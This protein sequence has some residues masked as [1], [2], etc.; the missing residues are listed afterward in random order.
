[1]AFRDYLIIKL[2]LLI[3]DTKICFLRKKKQKRFSSIPSSDI[4]LSIPIYKI[5]RRI[6]SN[7]T[8][9]PFLKTDRS[10]MVASYPYEEK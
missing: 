9:C 3:G 7:G 10:E 2:V 6:F 8:S 1:M 4:K 5:V